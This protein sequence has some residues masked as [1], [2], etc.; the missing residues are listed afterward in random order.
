MPR[1]FAPQSLYN[2]MGKHDGIK[3]REIRDSLRLEI[4]FKLL[5]YLSLVGHCYFFS[6]AAKQVGLVMLSE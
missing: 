3:G 4:T 2:M 1:Q 6:D 5:L